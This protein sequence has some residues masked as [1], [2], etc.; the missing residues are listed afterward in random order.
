[1]GVYLNPDN[2]NF[3]KTLAADIYV[4]KTRMI[5]Y[6]NRFIDKGNSYICVSR[7]RRFGK[8]ITGNMLSAYYSRGCDSAGLFSGYAISGDASFLEKINKFNVIQI[9]MNSEY[10]N[11]DDKNLF[12]K[13]LI[14]HIKDEFRQIFREIDFKDQD[15]LD[16]YILKTYQYTGCSF[17]IIM[18]EY[19]VLVRE[20][21]EE[22]LF[23]EYLGF[24]NG[25]FKSNPLRPAIALAY[26]TGIFPVVRDKVQSKLNNFREYTILDADEL[27]EFIGFTSDE[28]RTLCEKY[29][30]PFEECR[31]W[32]DGYRQGEL[33]IYNPESVIMALQKRR[34]GNYWSKTSSYE[35]IKERI[36]R[37]FAGTRDDVIK[38]LSGESVA[39]DEGMFLNT[40]EGINNKNEVFTYLSHLGY[41]SYDLNT[42]TCRIP[43]RE[44][45]NEWLRAIADDEDYSVTNSIIDSSRELLEKTLEGDGDAVAKALDISHIHVT[46]NRSY[47]NEDAL[48]S[49]I[50][51]AYIYALNKYTPVKE[52]TAGKGFADVVYI[53]FNP[54]NPAIIIELKRNDSSESALKQ[55]REK[56]YFE[57]LK[58]YRGD[59]VF[60]GIGYDEKTKK[61]SCKI[62]RF[63]K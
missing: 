2:E 1:M 17:V 23:N 57:A 49:A 19:D 41:L 51:L 18:D 53:P 28:V 46:S 54:D 7:P 61:H 21:A 29:K 5:A 36:R 31:N 8:T 62:E 37:N 9:D 56:N 3:I 55:I 45:R 59:L 14:D 43:N 63:E 24:L 38:M 20:N 15:S 52:M 11:A 16:R 34:F 22:K 10:Q 44:I 32:Y 39:V 60:V 42:G 30:V 58:H 12:L 48:Q 40:L 26:L 47:N 50:Y 33:E 27:A 25:L 35:V 6:A 4:D 13:R